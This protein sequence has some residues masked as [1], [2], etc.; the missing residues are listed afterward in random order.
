MRVD[1]FREECFEATEDAK[2]KYLN[3]MGNKLVDNQ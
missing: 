2:N 1:N 3:E